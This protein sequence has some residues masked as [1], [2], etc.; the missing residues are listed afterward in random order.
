MKLTGILLFCAE[1]L[2]AGQ[3]VNEISDPVKDANAVEIVMKQPLPMVNDAA[4]E[5]QTHLKQATGL[6]GL[7]SWNSS[8]CRH[9]KK[10]EPT[11]NS[12]FRKVVF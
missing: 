9:G 11:G 2:S 8:S 6:S 4:K 7:T 3:H 10:T 1:I 5:L 12:V